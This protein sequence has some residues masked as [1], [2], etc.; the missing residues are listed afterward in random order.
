MLDGR[1]IVLTGTPTSPVDTAAA[2]RA[3]VTVHSRKELDG[4]LVRGLAWTGAVKWTS[5]VVAWVSTLVV[6]RLLSPEDYGLVG[7]ATVYLG[8]VNLISEFGVGTTIVTLRDMSEEQIAQL[9]GFAVLLGLCGFAI[10]CLAA[11]PLGIFFKSPKLPLVVVAMST[12]FIISSFQSVPAALLQREL[13]FK[14]VS[15]IDG[16]RTITLA[17]TTVTLAFLGFRYWTLVCGAVLGTVTAAGMIL[18]RRRHRIAFPR[19]SELK[20]VLHFS[21]HVL[22]SRISWY[23]YSNS[24]FVVSGRVL[25]AQALGAYTVAWST[26]N[27]PVE[28][29]TGILN[30]VTPALFSAVQKHKAEMR[31]YLLNLTEGLALITLPLSIGLGLVAPEFVSVVLGPKWQGSIAPLR[32]LAFYVSVR[33]ITP[34]IPVVLN[35]VG[36][37]R[38]NMKMAMLTAIILPSAFYVGSRWGNTGI[39]VAWMIAYPCVA[40]P[41]YVRAFR[42]IELKWAEYLRMLS[43]SVLS[44]GVMAAAVLLAKATLPAALGQ[45]A[46]LAVLI[47]VGAAT[48]AIVAGG[49]NYRRRHRLRAIVGLL[50]RPASA[51]AV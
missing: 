13:R 12:N 36:Q 20:N 31:R 42:S 8:L 18:S 45:I 5:Q 3:G 14:L 39:A 32:F 10:S 28:K 7:M 15:V 9:N 48:Y 25:G 29:I 24:D 19:P 37:S 27:I 44:T 4:V 38:F 16:I 41:L 50:R 2:P 23:T 17:I 11:I 40:F 51:I 22:V 35:T 49:L 21:W 43:P 47:G 33:T 26:A 34:L 6:A 30:S 1:D 46:R